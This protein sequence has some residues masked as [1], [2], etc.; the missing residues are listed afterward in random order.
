MPGIDHKRFY[1]DGEGSLRPVPLLSVM[2]AE[3]ASAFDVSAEK[4]GIYISPYLASFFIIP[5]FLYFM[6]L[7]VPAAGV[8]GSVI[9]T[10]SFYYYI[11]TSF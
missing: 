11:R 3:T 1:P 4:A 2:L 7:G 9:G 10:F 8:L 6:Y 5:L